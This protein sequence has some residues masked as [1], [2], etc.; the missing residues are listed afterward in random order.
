MRSFSA[1]SIETRM[2]ER[3]R[4]PP[5]EGNG[6]EQ[7]CEESIGSLH[8]RG[9]INLVRRLGVSWPIVIGVDGVHQIE[10]GA[11]GRPPGSTRLAP[12]ITVSSMLPTKLERSVPSVD[13]LAGVPKPSPSLS[14]TTMARSPMASALLPLGEFAWDKLFEVPLLASPRPWSCQDFEG[15]TDS[16]QRS[17]A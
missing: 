6:Q 11:A 9:K 1:Y 14:T 12:P 7:T 17:C 4:L 13:V 10:S 8:L 15:F 16:L 2:S 5:T 3:G